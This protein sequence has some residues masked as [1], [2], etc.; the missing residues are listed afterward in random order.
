MILE[1]KFNRCFFFLL[2]PDY[3]KDGYPISLAWNITPVLFSIQV[4]RIG[5]E[6]VN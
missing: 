2:R 5:P 3:F 1:I 6:L 4:Q